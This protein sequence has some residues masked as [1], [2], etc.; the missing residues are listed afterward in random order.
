MRR[1]F[2]SCGILANVVLLCFLALLARNIYW[3][4]LPLPLYSKKVAAE[5]RT[6]YPSISFVIPILDFIASFEHKNYYYLN[7]DMKKWHGAGAKPEHQPQFAPNALIVTNTESLLS[8]LEKVTAGQ[9]IILEP[10]RYEF[11]RTINLKPSGTLNAPIRVTGRSLHDVIVVMNGEGFLV[12]TPYWQ[13]ENISFIGECK[14]H[15]DCHHALHIVGNATDIVIKNNVFRDFNAAIKVNGIDKHYPDRGL[16]ENNTFYNLES[17]NTNDPTTPIDIVAANDWKV[18]SNFIAD[19]QKS[20]GDGVSYAAFMKGNS[21]GGIFERNLVM[22]EANIHGRGH[23]ALGLSFG[24]GG[25]GASF[26][27]DGKT[28][29][30]ARKGIIR[31]NI[32]AHCPND[33]GIYL[34]RASEILV[35]NNIIYNTTGVD[36]RFKNSSARLFNNVISGRVSQRN[37]ASIVSESDY[38]VSRNFF[39]GKD[40]LKENFKNPDLIDFSIVN[41]FSVDPKVFFEADTPHIDFCNYPNKTSYLGAFNG[42]N[43]NC[44]MF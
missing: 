9:Q 15:D 4:G 23:I 6:N 3:Q 38:V 26:F 43:F 10:G 11:N 7:L 1:Y 39:T 44:Y 14:N 20:G 19:I 28:D 16:V 27:R 21:S 12:S 13:F 17:R 22:C 36:V 8:A 30:E 41:D 32:I 35:H 37:E 40:A 34:N 31:N 5:L 2:Y 25:T 18:S 24:G 42:K 29:V 33:V